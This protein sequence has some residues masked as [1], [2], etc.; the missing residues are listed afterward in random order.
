MRKAWM[1][2]VMLS[3]AM[4]AMAQ[5]IEVITPK[6]AMPEELVPL[7]RQLL[8]PGETVKV[9][10]NQLI[11]DASPAS[12]QRVRELLEEVDRPPRNILIQVSDAV[13][14]SDRNQQ[15]R[16]SGTVGSDDVRVSVNE[17]PRGDDH[18]HVRIEDSRTDA[19]ANIQQQVRAV[20][21]YPA[22]IA[23]GQQAPTTVVDM[24]GRPV[25][26]AQE[27]NQGFFATVRLQGGEVFIDISTS[28]DSLGDTQVSTRRTRTTVSGRLGEWIPLSGMTTQ[29]SSDTG[30]LGRSGTAASSASG[31][32]SLR[33]TLAD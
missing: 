11:V 22:F 7:V 15:V 14:G 19:R 33:V 1:I 32:L 10:R 13:T 24:Y 16:A 8:Q 26:V 20:E 18:L 12:L 21:G 2:L 31:T 6:G 17:R 5:Q 4:L 29:A 30:G 27:A 23:Q 3:W 28:H 25:V 9:F